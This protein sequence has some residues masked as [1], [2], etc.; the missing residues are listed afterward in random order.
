VREGGRE[1]K[2]GKGKGEKL[3]RRESG[4]MVEFYKFIRMCPGMIAFK[5]LAF[6]II[7]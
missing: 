2:E 6:G 1:E 4:E 5:I 3:R 7:G